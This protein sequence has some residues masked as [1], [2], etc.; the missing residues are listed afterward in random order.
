MWNEDNYIC[1]TCEMETEECELMIWCYMLNESNIDLSIKGLNFQFPT[2]LS[3]LALHCFIS[4]NLKAIL[5][6]SQFRYGR[7]SCSSTQ[8]VQ[9]K[10][11]QNRPCTMLGCIRPFLSPH[12]LISHS[13]FYNKKNLILTRL[14][15][16][17]QFVLGLLQHSLSWRE[18]II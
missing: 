1:W 7:S 9:W 12:L 17:F 2:N 10:I 5:R 3:C 11:Y 16:K 13:F 4:M 6:Q 14:K 15:H 8:V 18:C